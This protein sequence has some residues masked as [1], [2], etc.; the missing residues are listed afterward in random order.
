[1]RSYPVVSLLV[2]LSCLLPATPA[3]A[4]PILFSLPSDNT[5]MSDFVRAF[6]LPG[7]DLVWT[8]HSTSGRLDLLPP[9]G[10]KG[11]D[12]AT[13]PPN[14]LLPSPVPEP[15][16]VTVMFG[17]ALFGVLELWRRRTRRSI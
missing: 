11:P 15:S 3:M 17:A 5:L 12:W 7:P 4:G 16:G 10:P 14:V 13:A 8:L 1:M 6:G 9:I 2:A